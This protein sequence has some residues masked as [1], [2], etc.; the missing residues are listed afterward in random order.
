LG[1]KEKISK[2]HFVYGTAFLEVDHELKDV[3]ELFEVLDENNDHYLDESEF[4]AIFF[5]ADSW[6]SHYHNIMNSCLRDS[7]LMKT[8]LR[9]CGNVDLDMAYNTAEKRPY[10]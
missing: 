9:P 8:G 6:N 7:T 5:G 2:E 1:G 10:N 3:T 4:E